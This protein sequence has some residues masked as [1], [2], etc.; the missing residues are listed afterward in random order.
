MPRSYFVNF[1]KGR[2]ESPGY[3]KMLVIAKAMGFPPGAWFEDAPEAGLS[4]APV[5]AGTSP[6]G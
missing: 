4:S 1:T 6:R 2:I 3:E 5:G